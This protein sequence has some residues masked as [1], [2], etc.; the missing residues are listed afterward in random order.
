MVESSCA[1]LFSLMVLD[2]SRSWSNLPGCSWFSLA[3]YSI[4][5]GFLRAAGPSLLSSTVNAG[6]SSLISW[7]SVKIRSTWG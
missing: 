4:K 1:S 5:K 6:S 3:R 2:S 7:F